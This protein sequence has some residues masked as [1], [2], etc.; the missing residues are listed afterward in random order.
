MQWMLSMVTTG[1]VLH[2]FYILLK[3]IIEIDEEAV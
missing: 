1:I 2:I 3:D